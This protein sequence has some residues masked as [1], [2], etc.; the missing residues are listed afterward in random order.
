MPGRGHGKER[1][2]DY[3]GV[4]TSFARDV[5]VCYVCYRHGHFAR[6]C[7]ESTQRYHRDGGSRQGF[8]SDQRHQS[9]GQ[10]NRTSVVVEGSHLAGRG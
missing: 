7:P 10:V 9:R 3:E 5:G 1:Q 8:G 2:M 4:N 6:E